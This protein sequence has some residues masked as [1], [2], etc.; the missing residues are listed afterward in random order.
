MCVTI[1]VNTPLQVVTMTIHEWFFPSRGSNFSF[2]P[3]FPYKIDPR[4]HNK[5]IKTREEIKESNTTSIPFIPPTPKLNQNNQKSR[6]NPGKCGTLLLGVQRGPGPDCR[7]HEA[8]VHR[9]KV[10]VLH[11]AASSS[12]LVGLTASCHRTT[13]TCRWPPRFLATSSSSCTSAST[14]ALDADCGGSS[15]KP[16][17]AHVTA[18]FSSAGS[19]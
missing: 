16:P 15:S 10:H 18:A 6:D 17:R 12:A 11:L 4:N 13:P 2:F 5:T 7:L 3:S 14:C 9:R 1:F 8:L 19:V